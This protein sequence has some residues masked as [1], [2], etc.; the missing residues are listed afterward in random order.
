M[1]LKRILA[2][3]ALGLLVLVLF[4]NFNDVPLFRVEC[5]LSACAKADLLNLSFH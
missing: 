2:R 3:V 4:A 5:A 1:L